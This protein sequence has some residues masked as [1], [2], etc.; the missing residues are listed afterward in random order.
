MGRRFLVPNL[1]LPSSTT[2][3]FTGTTGG[4]AV[5]PAPVFSRVDQ[6]QRSA[7]TT[8]LSITLGAV[9]AN[10]SLMVMAIFMQS[11]TDTIT[12]PAGWTKLD[13]P[14]TTAT[15]GDFGA[16]LHYKVASSETGTYTATKT[17]TEGSSL[18]IVATYTGAAYDT[19]TKDIT[20]GGG[21]RTNAVL[22]AITTSTTN[23][24]L[25]YLAG[26]RGVSNTATPA[27]GYTERLDTGSANAPNS[28]VAEMVLVP[29][30]TTSP[31]TI[32]KV[33]SSTD[34]VYHVSLKPA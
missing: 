27:S 14:S 20:A 12:T 29:A 16:Y 28:E 33:L 21:A 9:P 19:F 23:C 13:G 32:T 34:C 22:P 3:P 17:G 15:G 25:V 18:M 6:Q 30:S 8:A 4:V 31:G 26:F 11:D 1:L 5:K 10:G 24:M 2:H 7:A